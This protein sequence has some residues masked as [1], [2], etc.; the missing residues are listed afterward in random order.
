MRF[1]VIASQASARSGA[2][3]SCERHE[4]RERH[5]A[6]GHVGVHVEHASVGLEVHAAGVEQ[7]ALADQRDIRPR[8]AARRAGR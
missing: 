5:R 8:G 2:R 7:D 4:R 3:S 6:A 1:S